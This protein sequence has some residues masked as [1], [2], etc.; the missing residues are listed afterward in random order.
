MEN[1]QYV[2]SIH[3]EKNICPVYKKLQKEDNPIFIWGVGALA[4]N[5]YTYCR[6]YDIKVCGCFINTT[7]NTDCFQGL[8][9]FGMG[10]LLEA[11]SSFSVI[12]GHSDYENGLKDLQGI[13]NIK[14]I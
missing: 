1:S 5:V 11:Y 9:V 12:I 3:I 14:N 4:K 13:E 6:K 2:S 10:E 8:P 7:L